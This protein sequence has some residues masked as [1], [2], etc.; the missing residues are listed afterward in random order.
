M[1][2]Y[3]PNVGWAPDY[4]SEKNIPPIPPIY[5]DSLTLYN[6]DAITKLKQQNDEL[7]KEN[8]SLKAQLNKALDEKDFHKKM[9]FRSAQFADTNKMVKLEEELIDT[10]RKLNDMDNH[11]GR[12]T[13]I[14]S[15]FAKLWDVMSKDCYFRQ[16]ATLSFD[17]L[18]GEAVQTKAENSAWLSSRPFK[19]A[20]EF[21]ESPKMPTSNSILVQKQVLRKAELLEESERRLDNS[22]VKLSLFASVVLTAKSLKDWQGSEWLS[23]AGQVGIDFTNAVNQITDVDINFAETV[24]G[25]RSETK[26]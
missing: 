24:I 20:S 13:L 16:V 23:M 1:T 26:A 11:L 7:K 8:T 2:E 19:E 10:K 14:L 4:D 21:L 17:R 3:T 12:A 22:D 9:S 6:V 18:T 25:G 5:S 15:P